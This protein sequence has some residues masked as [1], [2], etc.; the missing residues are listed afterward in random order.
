MNRIDVINQFK[1][2][3][4]LEI[5][6]NT[7]ACFKNVKCENKKGVDPNSRA[8]THQM[9]SN[10]FFQQN[11]ETFDLIFIDGDHKGE[12]VEEDIVNAWGCLNKGGL[13][14]LHDVN[15]ATEAEQAETKISSPWRGT[16][17]RAWVGLISKYPKLNTY[18]TKQDTGLGFLYKSR[19]KIEVGFIDKETS[20]EEFFSN[21]SELLRLVK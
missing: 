10:Q 2:Q 12:Q 17:W 3:S 6:V 11:E 14:L 18:T 7:G 4:Y 19:H 9:T 16:V 21:K 1:P 8:A 5:G 13:I 15:P 20:F